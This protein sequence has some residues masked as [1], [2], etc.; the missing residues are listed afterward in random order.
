MACDIYIAQ[1]GGGAPE[2]IQQKQQPLRPAAHAGLYA[3]PGYYARPSVRQAN[4]MAYPP[5]RPDTSLSNAMPTWGLRGP[6]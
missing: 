1:Y 5:P 3:Q 2:D 4:P 6:R